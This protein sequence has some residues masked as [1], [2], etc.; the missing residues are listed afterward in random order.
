MTW[1]HALVENRVRLTKTF[2]EKHALA[3]SDSSNNERAVLY[4]TEVRGLILR[5]SS[6]GRKT[7]SI[8]KKL[9]GRPVRVTLGTFP[10]LS[11]EQARKLAQEVLSDI[12]HGI[13]PNEEKKG[14]PIRQSGRKL[15][16]K[17]SNL[18]RGNQNPLCYHY[19]TGYQDCAI[20]HQ[21]GGPP[22]ARVGCGRSHGF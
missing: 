18:E 1:S 19:T 14:R 3:P 17:D 2:I 20:L 21:E 7:F 9:N 12:A 11:V 6:S 8:F 10:D 15:P 13:N 4:D 16:G 22:Q 5:V